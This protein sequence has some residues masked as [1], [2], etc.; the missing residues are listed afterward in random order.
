MRKIGVLLPQSKA[1]PKLAKEFIKGLRLSQSETNQYELKIEGI[2]Y[3]NDA[4]Q[5]IDGIQKL[6]NQEQVDLVTGIVGHKG[7]SEVL[8]YIENI[9]ETFIYSDLG[10]TQPLDLSNRKG[11]YCNSMGL[12]DATTLLGEHLISNNF[13]K[14]GTSTCYYESGYGFIKLMEDSIAG[15][16]EFSG[17]FISPIN[18]RKNEAELM[19]DWYNSMNPDALFAFHNGIFSEEHA[20]FLSENKLHEKVPIYSLPFS[21]EEDVVNKFPEVFNDTHC[22]TS[23]YADLNTNENTSFI[24]KYMETY[25]SKPTFFAVLGYENGILINDFLQNSNTFSTQKKEG[26]RGQIEFT[27]NTNRTNYKHYLYQLRH[28]KDTCT[29][30]HIQIFKKE[31]ISTKKVFKNNIPSWDNAY[32]CY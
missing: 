25:G 13:L 7:L 31:D 2:G 16:G 19:L 22:I 5:S 32:L 26:P 10:A 11:I 12:Y 20:S 23:W 3:G 18:P 14:I 28:E 27:T 6:V 21:C 30:A 4:K 29:K 17:H 9:E 24:N 8:D 15:K 1:Y